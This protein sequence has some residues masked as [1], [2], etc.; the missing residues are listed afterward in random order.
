M[1]SPIKEIKLNV[2][3]IPF[4]K[5]KVVEIARGNAKLTIKV[6]FL[7]LKNIHKNKLAKIN[8]CNALFPTVLIDFFILSEESNTLK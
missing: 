1:A 3:C 7:F 6:I 2:E 8:P 5:I 4:I